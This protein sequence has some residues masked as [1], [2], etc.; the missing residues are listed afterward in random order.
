MRGWSAGVGRNC[1][2][3]TPPSLSAPHLTRIVTDSVRSMCVVW[4]FS[5]DFGRQSRGTAAL[6]SGAAEPASWGVPA[7]RT[8]RRRHGRGG[9]ETACSPG[10]PRPVTGGI[11]RPEPG[12]VR[13][14]GRR[15]A[16]SRPGCARSSFGAD[17]P[18][19]VCRPIAASAAASTVADSYTGISVTLMVR[20]PLTPLE[21]ERGRLLGELLRSARG[22]RTIVEVAARAGI[23]AETLRKIE[24]GRAPTPAFFTV[25]AL[26]TELDLGLDE[27]T[28]RCAVAQV[29]EP[30]AV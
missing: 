21:R 13:R 2:R 7:C 15:P 23:S 25:A 29:P 26:V 30:E 10:H 4:R 18:S 6:C 1:P 27:V 12:G 16:P 5:A 28:A 3:H 11:A 17:G 24:T 20:T 9:L 14:A 8:D 19:C 22:E